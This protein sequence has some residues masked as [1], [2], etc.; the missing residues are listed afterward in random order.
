[1]AIARAINSPNDEWFFHANLAWALE[2]SGACAS[3]EALALRSA[4]L[5]FI[6]HGRYSHPYFWSAFSIYGAP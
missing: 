6:E 1:L 5:Q 3:D 2:R 4:Q